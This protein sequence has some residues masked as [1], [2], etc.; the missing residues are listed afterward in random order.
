VWITIYTNYKATS[1]KN[2]F[3]YNILKGQL[4]GELKKLKTWTSNDKGNERIV[5]HIKEVLA[6]LKTTKTTLGNIF[7]S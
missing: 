4:W 5:L 1:L 6:Q 7:K 2:S 3:Q